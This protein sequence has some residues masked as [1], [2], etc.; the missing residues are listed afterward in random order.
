MAGDALSSG[1]GSLGSKRALLAAG[2]LAPLGA[3]ALEYGD[4]KES[5]G[6]NT[7][8]ALGAGIGATAALAPLALGM[9]GPVGWAAAAGL[10]LLGS[11][12]GKGVTRAATDA[13]G[14]TTSPKPWMEEIEKGRVLGQLALEQERLKRQQNLTLAKPELALQREHE[15]GLEAIRRDSAY[16]A[17]VLG[18]IAQLNQGAGRDM[19]ALYDR[20]LTTPTVFRG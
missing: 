18:A 15:A 19:A 13:L 10:G 20:A 4:S 17:A 8:D 9:T 11:Q 2:A 7:A 3:A 6:Q 14:F 1:L 16:Q 5:A 12:V